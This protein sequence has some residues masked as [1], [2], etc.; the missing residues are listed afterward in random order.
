MEVSKAEEKKAEVH[1]VIF[2]GVI[3]DEPN[4]LLGRLKFNYWRTKRPPIVPID[5]KWIVSDFD[6]FMGGNPHEKI[7]RKSALNH[8]FKTKEEKAK[9][10]AKAKEEKKE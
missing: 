8:H 2:E 1:F 5:D 4:T 3:Y 7:T 9:D 6:D 10:E